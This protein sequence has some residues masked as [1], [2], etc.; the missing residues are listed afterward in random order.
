MNYKIYNKNLKNI[1]IIGLGKVGLPLSVCYA[2]KGFKVIGVDINKKRIQNL[3]GG[4]FILHEPKF[5]TL[6]QK[7]QNRI[8]FSTDL[9]YA[10]KISSSIFII[11]PTPS[12]KNGNYSL[13]H[14]LEVCKRISNI[15][16]NESEWKLITVI[17][18][19]IPGSMENKIK[20]ALEN[21]SHK[22]A[23]VEFGLCYSPEFVALGNIIDN[24]FHPDFILIGQSD[25]KSGK[26]LASI[27]M[28]VCDNIPPVY[29]TNFVNAE[30][31]KIGSNTFITTKIS[32]AN[33]LARICEKIPGA[34]VDSITSI[35]SADSSIGG[36]RLFGS[37][38]YS[39]P[40]YPR[41]NIAL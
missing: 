31:A 35:L 28:Q 6:F 21:G 22:K 3:Q 32:F 14:I 33:M 5:S 23:G 24:F 11:V 19:G 41:D 30:L 9:E 1:A 39:G 37:I 27:K 40:C 18:T 29:I 34:N 25:K 36:K 16:R 17:S 8:T 12:Q 15:L 7:Y 38:G 13:K 10:I 2:S 26:I 4:K 20:P